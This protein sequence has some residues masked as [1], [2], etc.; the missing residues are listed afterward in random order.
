MTNTHEARL[1]EWAYAEHMHL[2]QRQM[3]VQAVLDDLAEARAQVE[4]MREALNALL[5][6]FEWLLEQH[7]EHEGSYSDDRLADIRELLAAAVPDPEGRKE[8]YCANCGKPIH[9]DRK[10]WVHAEGNV[11][12]EPSLPME[13][14]PEWFAKHAAVPD[15]EEDA[16]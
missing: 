1:R 9:L 2:G 8:S 5:G 15:P 12:C 10:A 13:D 4:R 11:T 14:T 3:D 7:P 6:D 16:T